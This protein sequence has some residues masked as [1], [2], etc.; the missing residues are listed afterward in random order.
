MKKIIGLGAIK[1][2]L[3]YLL[4][5]IVVIVVALV[6]LAGFSFLHGII[7]GA[8]NFFDRSDFIA[9]IIPGMNYIYGLTAF[10]LLVIGL[11]GIKFITP[12]EKVEL[13]FEE[14]DFTP[15]KLSY[16]NKIL[17]MKLRFDL[18]VYLAFWYFV[19]KHKGE[20]LT[21]I[22]I[23][24]ILTGYRSLTDYSILYQDAIVKH[25]FFNP[26]GQI[27]RWEDIEEVRVGIKEKRRNYDYY[28]AIQF[29]D[30]TTINLNQHTNISSHSYDSYDDRLIIDH[31]IK[32]LGINKIIDRS[33]LDKW[34]NEYYPDHVEKVRKLFED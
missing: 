23:A 13:H 22:L 19:G 7:A 31:R 26:R 32:M 28:Y 10:V 14:V 1:G 27:Y 17:Y 9:Y 11:F 4:V 8:D 25:S 24:F 29:Q 2:I 3:G 20:V 6:S 16:L 30:K 21:F 33:N 12:V 34:G 15:N 18:R 5:I